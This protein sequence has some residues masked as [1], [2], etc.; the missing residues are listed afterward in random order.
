MI[1]KQKTAQDI[2]KDREYNF[3]NP[4]CSLPCGFGT[5]DYLVPIVI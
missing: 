1:E 4:V 5:E 2:F 3:E